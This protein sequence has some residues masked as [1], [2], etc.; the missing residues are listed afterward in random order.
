MLLVVVGRR[1]LLFVVDC[2]VLVVGCVLSVVLFDVRDCVL[3]F[4][5]CC[6]L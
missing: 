6:L 4:V 5:V 1:C 2:G 3:M